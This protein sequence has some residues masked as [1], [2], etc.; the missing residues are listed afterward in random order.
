MHRPDDPVT[1]GEM[2]TVINRFKGISQRSITL[3][4]KYD[5]LEINPLVIS[6]KG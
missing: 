1:W 2:A 5:Q 6:Y 4:N 3:K